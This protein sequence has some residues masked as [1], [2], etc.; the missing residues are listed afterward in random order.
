MKHLNRKLYSALISMIVLIF[1][2]GPLTV[3][4]EAL[5]AGQMAPDFTLQTY[6][7]NDRVT[8]GSFMGEKP[9]V[10]IFGSYT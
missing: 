8:L 2:G 6:E 10:L 4:A 7:R 1:L 5:K 9:V 3:N